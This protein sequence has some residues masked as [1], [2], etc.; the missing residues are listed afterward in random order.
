MLSGVAHRRKSSRTV[1]LSLALLL[2]ACGG[3]GSPPSMPPPPTGV[4]VTIHYL[5]VD[6]AYD[7]WGLHLWGNAIAASVATTWSSPRLPDRVENG[8]AVFAI[9]V[10][11][12][13][14]NL[15]FIAHNGD[16]K[17]P[18]YDLSIVPRTF[19]RE[20]WIVQDEVAALVGTIGTPFSSE[21]SALAALN[22][23][24]NKSAALELGSVV[25]NDVDSGLAV[26]WT[27][28]ASFIEIYVRAYQDSDGDGVG[29]LQGLISRLDY[30]QQLG[31]TGIWLMPVTESADNDHGYAVQDYREIESDYG[32]MSDF[33]TLL[34][35]AHSRGIAVIID[36]V[37]NHAASTNPLFLDASTTASNNKRD[38]FIWANSK[39][40]GWNTFAG[41]PWRNNG[42]GWYYGVFS[43]LMPDF[44]LRNPAVV[45]YHK[46]NL[47][48][49]L[50]KGVDGF[51]FDAVGVLFEN[52]ATEWEDQPENHALLAE[53]LTLVE[54]YSKRFIVCEAPSNPGV[55]ANTA[56]CGRAFA[57]QTPAAILN[58]ARTGAADNLFVNQLKLA[59]SD[60]MPLIL[61]NHDSFAGARI[62]NQLSGDTADYKLAAASYLLAAR[63]PFIYYGEEI[64]MAGAAALSGDAAL[65]TPMSWT[66]DPGNAGFSTVPPFRELAANST[67]QNVELESVDGASLL[68]YYNEILT[69]RKDYPAVGAGVPDVQSA[70]GD[71]LLLVIRNSANACAVIAIN[72]SSIA[73]AYTATTSCAIAGFSRVLGGGGTL[74]SDGT[75]TVSGV[76]PPAGATVDY[77][78]L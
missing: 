8:A 7:G 58:S 71:P 12:E 19:G 23:L 44:N 63:T 9:P 10:F 13:T 50:N 25:E 41:D 18:I 61:S 54:G 51:R 75:G 72:Y 56:S 30:L 68:N 64:G 29:D 74:T 33:E 45:E 28:T 40:P 77:A 46:D 65:R 4:T 3:G 55:Y 37:M 31:V 14:Q 27:N 36:Y 49:W 35:E 16:L 38:W 62:W 53:I 32:S 24:G 48:F 20:I 1:A 43:A 15:N 39:P 52:G 76:V 78:A 26:G 60:R 5:R 21:A 70:G 69:V 17:S 6:P 67:T 47:R 11:D 2:A 22:A 59:N 57:F 73:Q 66:S 34:I 42:N